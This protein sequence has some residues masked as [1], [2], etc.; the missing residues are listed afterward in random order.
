MKILEWITSFFSWLQIVFFPT[1]IGAIA[2]LIFYYNY[3]SNMGLIIAISIG[4]LGLVIGVTLATRIWKKQG[5]TAFI[6]R[7]SASPELDNLEKDDE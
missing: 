5:T 3:S 2:A 4:I 7:A 6:S 1:F